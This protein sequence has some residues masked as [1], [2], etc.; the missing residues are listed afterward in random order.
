[1]VTLQACTGLLLV[2]VPAK[3]LI[4]LVGAPGLEPGTR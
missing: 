2:D 4:L 1:L 3:C